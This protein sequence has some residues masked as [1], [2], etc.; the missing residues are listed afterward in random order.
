MDVQTL[1]E[2]RTRGTLAIRKDRRERSSL[3]HDL[4]MSQSVLDHIYLD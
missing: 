2:S 1:G 3:P 4:R